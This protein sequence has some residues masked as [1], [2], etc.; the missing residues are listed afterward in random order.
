MT[1]LTN[2][3]SAPPLWLTT[4]LVNNSSL[5]VLSTE[6]LFCLTTV[7]AIVFNCHDAVNHDDAVNCDV[8]FNHG[9]AHLVQVQAGHLTKKNKKCPMYVEPEPEVLEPWIPDVMLTHPTPQ[10]GIITLPSW[11][12]CIIFS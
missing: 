9:D 3:F 7:L 1:F 12:Q 5:N 2:H 11:V 10:V 4:F 8:V 6:H